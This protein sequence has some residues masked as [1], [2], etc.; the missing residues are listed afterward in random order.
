M[1]FLN[2]AVLSIY[3][4]IIEKNWNLGLNFV[5]LD[6]YCDF[7]TFPG[8]SSLSKFKRMFTCISSAMVSLFFGP[9]YSMLF[10]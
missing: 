4:F 9:L 3:G 7:R 5:L 8:F 1:L 2:E 10:Y 6:W